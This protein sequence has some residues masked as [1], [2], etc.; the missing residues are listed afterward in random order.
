MVT[1]IDYDVGNIG[2]IKNIL[3]RVGADKVVVSRKRDDILEAD[4]IVLPGVGAYDYGMQKL[5]DCG[6]KDTLD[7]AVLMRKIPILGICL[8]MQLLGESS[9][10]GT[11]KGLSYIPFHCERFD[12]TQDLKVPHMGW[13]RVELTDNY[14]PLTAD[15]DEDL[16]FYFVHSYYAICDKLENVIMN[17]EYG[18]R[19]AAAVQ[20][21]NVF[22]VQFHPEKS[23]QFGMGLFR[24]FMEIKRD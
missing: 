12:S 22:G 18:V 17:C 5:Y 11:M 21:D 6:I 1:I 8:G 9:A 20:K 16:R 19:F 7:E 23:H 2:S 3:H 15:L 14:S 4:R 10:E 13:D 24:R